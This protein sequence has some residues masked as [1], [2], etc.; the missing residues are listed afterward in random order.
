MGTRSGLGNALTLAAMM[1]SSLVPEAEETAPDDGTKEDAMTIA[2][3][4][5]GRSGEVWRCHADDCVA[6]VIGVMATKRIGA[7][8]VERPVE[9]IRPIIWPRFT[10]VLSAT[11]IFERWP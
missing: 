1:A 4:I 6:D 5:A 3:L 10:R 7:L 11:R 9:P 8:P 2:R